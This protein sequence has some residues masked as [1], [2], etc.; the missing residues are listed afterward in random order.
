MLTIYIS[1][2]FVS[3]Y[4]RR[5]GSGGYW[6]S[7][8]SGNLKAFRNEVLSGSAKRSAKENKDKVCAICSVINVKAMR[9]SCHQKPMFSE[10]Q[11]KGHT[12][13]H[14]IGYK[15]FSGKINLTIHYLYPQYSL[16]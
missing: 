3:I 2:N 8:Q 4:F 6:R 16:Y 12:Y 10:L 13:S 15:M 11:K 5:Q 7:G 9:Q 14:T 1:C